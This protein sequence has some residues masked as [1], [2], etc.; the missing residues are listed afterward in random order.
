MKILIGVIVAAVV[1]IGGYVVFSQQDTGEREHRDGEHIEEDGAM[2]EE[3]SF[4]GSLFDLGARGGT[5]RCTFSHSS[6]VGTSNGTVYIS[7]ERIRGDFESVAQ[8]FAIESHMLALSGTIYSWSPLA[9]TGVKL[10]RNDVEGE[11]GAAMS[12]DYADLQQA[13]AYDCEA[14][15]VD[16]SVFEIPSSV[17]FIE[18]GT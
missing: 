8:G 2:M 15:S 11:G 5:Y 7:G 13:Y 16:E 12:G 14:W 17:T 1:L 9:P 4:S 6:E 10:P 3:G 18:A